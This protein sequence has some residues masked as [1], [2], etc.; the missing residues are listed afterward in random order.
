MVVSH[1]IIRSAEPLR[2]DAAKSSSDAALGASDRLRCRSRR[3]L[4]AYRTTSGRCDPRYVIREAPDEA[5][6]MHGAALRT[7][8]EFEAVR[9]RS[10]SR[11]RHPKMRQISI[12]LK[13]QEEE[14]RRQR[15]KAAQEL[16]A[17]SRKE[18][19]PVGMFASHEQTDRSPRPRKETH[20]NPWWKFW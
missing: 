4:V 17:G 14:R 3:C 5:A 19:W 20:S 9:P 15:E 12:I 8:L 7:G 1:R 10:E 11:K 13:R 18:D 2:G 6:D 16:T